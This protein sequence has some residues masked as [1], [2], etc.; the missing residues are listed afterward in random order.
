MITVEELKEKI[1]KELNNP[2]SGEDQ[3]SKKSAY[4]ILVSLESFVDCGNRMINM[5]R[6][7]EFKQALSMLPYMDTDSLKRGMNYIFA[8][9]FEHSNEI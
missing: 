2:R 4:F 5:L 6:L 3:E 9:Y 7:C 8:I 1:V